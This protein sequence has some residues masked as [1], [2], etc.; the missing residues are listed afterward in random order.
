M[1]PYIGK[2]YVVLT[3]NY[4]GI[5]KHAYW[6]KDGDFGTDFYEILRFHDFWAAYAHAYEHKVPFPL[7]IAMYERI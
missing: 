5:N 7:V 3:L 1:L 6:L 2:Y 4:Y